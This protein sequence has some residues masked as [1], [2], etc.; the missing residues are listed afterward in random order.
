M[1]FTSFIEAVGVS[2]KE[3][4]QM[5]MGSDFHLSLQP[6]NAFEYISNLGPFS[7]ESGEEGED[8]E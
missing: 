5:K 2:L 8:C 3:A 6:T 1:S 7:A 4:M